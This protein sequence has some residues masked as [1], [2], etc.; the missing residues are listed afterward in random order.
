[1]TLS[2]PPCPKSPKPGSR[3]APS[4][5][6]PWQ[7]VPPLEAAAV[8][9]L[10]LP[11][12][13]RAPPPPPPSPPPPRGPWHAPPPPLHAPSPQLSQLL[14]RA[15]ARPPSSPPPP[16]PPP[17]PRALVSVRQPR[18]RASP[19]LPPRPPQA[20]T[21]P[22]A[23]GPPERRSQ[24]QYPARCAAIQLCGPTAR[25]GRNACSPSSIPR[26]RAPS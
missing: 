1:M 12:A 20:V 18:P 4:P 2:T 23:T 7:R 11:Y 26:R 8:A 15:H 21:R 19:A 6:L 22:H 17:P 9:P 13:S 16:P 24:P 5:L 14:P 25:R 10:R 3:R